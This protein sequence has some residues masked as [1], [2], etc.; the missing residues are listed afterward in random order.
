MCMLLLKL[1]ASSVF[2]LQLIA[3]EECAINTKITCSTPTVFN[4]AGLN[5]I[6][7]V[8]IK[9][10]ITRM[11]D[12]DFALKMLGYSMEIKPTLEVVDGRLVLFHLAFSA[13]STTTIEDTGVK[14]ADIASDASRRKDWYP[15]AMLAS[16]TAAML[17]TDTAI[18]LV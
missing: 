13:S 6:T 17:S 18:D 9:P 4:L 10:R 16:M 2:M 15:L 5:R 11:S 8:G 1:A 7:L 12:K 14:V 3:S